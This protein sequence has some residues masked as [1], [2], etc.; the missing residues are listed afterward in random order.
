MTPPQTAPTPAPASDTNVAPTP[1][2]RRKTI[3]ISI[4]AGV[5]ALIVLLA[6]GIGITYA[7]FVSRSESGW[8]RTVASA[9]P[10]PAAK[11]GS[12]DILYRDFLK[13]RDTVKV[14]IASEAA[15]DQGL[16]VPFDVALETNVL[17]KLIRQAAV[18]EQAA[19]KGIEVTDSELRAFFSDVVAAAS[20][21]TPD[22]GVYLLENFGWNEEDFRQNVLKPALL[23][24][25]VGTALAEQTQGDTTAFAAWLEERLSRSDVVRY[26]RFE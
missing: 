10:I 1:A 22:V 4:I 25:R 17:E 20:S 16:D 3:I 14:F 6:V 21:T 8:V 2:S 23:E 26:L 13:T 11:V 15:K 18:E 24:Q 12:R 7:V 9:L 19:E 5:T